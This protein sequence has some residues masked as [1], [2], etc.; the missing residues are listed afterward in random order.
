M[1]WDWN[2][3]P[4]SLSILLFLAQYAFSRDLYMPLRRPGVSNPQ[5][6]DSTYTWDAGTDS[7][8]LTN[9]ANLLYC[10]CNRHKPPGWVLGRNT[11]TVIHFYANVTCCSLSRH[12]HACFPVSDK[13]GQIGDKSRIRLLSR[14]IFSAAP[15]SINTPSFLE[16]FATGINCLWPSVPPHHQKLSNEPW[17]HGQIVNSAVTLQQ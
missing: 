7:R 17:T 6:D 8:S 11:A 9:V 3:N 10:C 4:E 5:T 16:P 13:N 15:M 14:E 1:K 2:T 12:I